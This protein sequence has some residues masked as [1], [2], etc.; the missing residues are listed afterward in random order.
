[1]PAPK[2]PQKRVEWI[3]RCSEGQK[4]KIRSA[5]TRK[6]IALGKIDNSWNRGRKVPEEAI[7]HMKAAQ[8]GRQV[9]LETRA[10]WSA[11]R[12]GKFTGEK[13]PNWKGGISFGVY[14]PKFNTEFK[15]RV[16]EFWGR[17]CFICGKTESENGRKLD[18]H[19]VNYDKGVCCNN[20]KPLFIPL[21]TKCHGITT[22][23]DREKMSKFLTEHILRVSG[24]ECYLPRVI[25]NA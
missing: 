6:K 9:S 7:S 19:H 5:E 23:S 25:K 2:D 16:R 11:Q 24:G 15:E 4:G 1:M 20:E 8:K 13:H 17:M 14:C 18:V 21:C 22:T 12:K 3:R 10:L